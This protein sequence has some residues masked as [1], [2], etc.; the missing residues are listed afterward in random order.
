MNF[1]PETTGTKNATGNH[2]PLIS[3]KDLEPIRA[4]FPGIS[5]KSACLAALKAVVEELA[6]AKVAAELANKA[7]K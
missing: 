5:A 6:A 7:K 4:F 3:D 2:Y 1:I